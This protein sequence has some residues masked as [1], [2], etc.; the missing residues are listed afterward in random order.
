[1]QRCAI[2]DLP[3]PEQ[4]PCFSLAGESHQ[5]RIAKALSNLG[6]LAEVSE[7]TRRVASGSV[8]ECSGEE[9]VAS[10]DAVMGASVEQPLCASDP[11]ISRG[12]I[13]QV[14]EDEGDP[15]G[16]ARRSHRVATLE[17]LP[18]GPCPGVHTVRKLPD[19]EGGYGKPLQVDCRERRLFVRGGQRVV[20]ITPRATAEGLPGPFECV[21]TCHGLTTS[22]D[23]LR[24]RPM[25][26]SL[27]L[28]AAIVRRR[29]V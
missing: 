4:S 24:G 19:E 5:I 8:A 11:A 15:E 28:S 10:L 23:R 18:M 29:N 2:R 17:E 9:Q 25:S 20:G 14:E 21:G 1:E 12:H 22:R 6:S 7:R 13:A 26:E 3:H 16:A 27:S